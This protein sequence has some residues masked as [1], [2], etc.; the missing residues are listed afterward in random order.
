MEG[1][2]ILIRFSCLGWQTLSTTMPKL[3]LELLDQEVKG[4]STKNQK[5]FKLSGYTRSSGILAKRDD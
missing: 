5:S 2:E 4:N 3:C 1:L